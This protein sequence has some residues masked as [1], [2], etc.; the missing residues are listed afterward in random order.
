MPIN[1]H[2][3]VQTYGGHPFCAKTTKRLHKCRVAPFVPKLQ[4]GYINVGWHPLCQNYKKATLINVGWHPLCQN[5]KKDYIYKCRVTW[6]LNK[7]EV[8]FINM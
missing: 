6:H 2:T 8:T 5:Y 7:C 1:E 4:K 3:K